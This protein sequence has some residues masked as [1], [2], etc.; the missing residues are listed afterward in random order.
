MRC[1]DALVTTPDGCGEGTLEREFAGLPHSQVSPTGCLPS[2]WPVVCESNTCRGKRV[3]ELAIERIA[4][5]VV[6]E[7]RSREHARRPRI[8]L[9]CEGQQEMLGLD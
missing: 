7:S 9:D 5:L 3:A 8:V 2:R 6:V 1:L 4:E